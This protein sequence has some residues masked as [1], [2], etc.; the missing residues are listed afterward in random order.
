MLTPFFHCPSRLS[1]LTDSSPR[2]CKP[3]LI[4]RS[5]IEPRILTY[6]NS[7]AA[8]YVDLAR[9]YAQTFNEHVY[10]PA[11]KIVRHGY[12]TYGAPA[13]DRARAYSQKQWQA[14]VVPRLNSAQDNVNKI[15]TTKV[16]P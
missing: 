16:D 5:H 13:L 4:A 3:Y 1:E 12:D 9:P 11:A 8:P 6:Y 7:Y 14:E 10:S 2:V 15:Y